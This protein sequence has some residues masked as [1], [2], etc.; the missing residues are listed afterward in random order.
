MDKSYEQYLKRYRTVKATFAVRHTIH[1]LERVVSAA[2][3]EKRGELKEF[4]VEGLAVCA[5]SEPMDVPGKMAVQI[6]RRVR[7]IKHLSQELERVAKHAARYAASDESALDGMASPENFGWLKPLTETMN[8]FAGRAETVGHALGDFTRRK[9]GG[10]RV[11]HETMLADRILAD[12]KNTFYIEL[13]Q[14]LNL[15]YEA[16]GSTR[17]V[18]A[19]QLRMTV[20]RHPLVQ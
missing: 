18:N 9:V 7:R 6:R 10:L 14:L 2:P 15:A 17:T 5:A 19:S 16:A 13:A 1:E 3:Q 12:T 11:A 20:N 4:L 8:Y